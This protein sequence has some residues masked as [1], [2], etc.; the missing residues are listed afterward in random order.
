MSSCK[1]RRGLVAAILVLGLLSACDGDN[2]AEPS[3]TEDSPAESPPTGGVTLYEHPDYRGA[4]YML[5]RDEENLDSE[6]GPCIATDD[7]TAR[8]WDECVSSIAITDG[9][10][11]EVFEHPEY[12]GLSRT[13]TADVANLR[14]ETE[15]APDSCDGGWNDCISSLRV[16]PVN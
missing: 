7:P 10:Q 8:S 4:S 5:T 9:W 2:P 15:D 1:Q 6:R 14:A 11:A 13:F 3:P 16:S 12:R